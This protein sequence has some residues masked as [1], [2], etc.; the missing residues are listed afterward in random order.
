MRGD[1][2]RVA[3]A[4]ILLTC[5]PARDDRKQTNLSWA[6]ASPPE[7]PEDENLVLLVFRKHHDLRA[8]AHLPNPGR[9]VPQA[10]QPRRK[11]P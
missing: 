5:P 2:F 11:E 9:R 7:P 10:S 3:I 6:K 1:L 8:I 4:N